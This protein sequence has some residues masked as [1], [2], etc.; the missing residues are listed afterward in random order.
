MSTMNIIKAT[1]SR[2][3]QYT[4]IDNNSRITLTNCDNMKKI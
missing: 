4:L 3:K 1:E 2:A